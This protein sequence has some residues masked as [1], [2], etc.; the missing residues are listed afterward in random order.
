MYS[1]SLR[2]W[3]RWDAE[4]GPGER[5]ARPSVGVGA[6]RTRSGKKR[7]VS[8]DCFFLPVEQNRSLAESKERPPYI[9]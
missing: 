4:T 5:G 9:P 8:S 6:C 2:R 1:M 7:K 3:H